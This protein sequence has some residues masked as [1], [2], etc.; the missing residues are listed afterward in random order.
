M[1][2]FFKWNEVWSSGV[3]VAFDEHCQNLFF[4]NKIIG[5]YKFQN[6]KKLVFP[7][8]MMTALFGLSWITFHMTT[9]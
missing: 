7:F 3:T 8:K 2:V 6:R 1:D 9:I 4:E 5:V